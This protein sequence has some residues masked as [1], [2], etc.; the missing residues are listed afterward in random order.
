MS[1]GQDVAATAP[2]QSGLKSR[3]WP[4]FLR[5]PDPELLEKLYVPALNEAL[6]YDRC[7]AYF[8]SNVLAAAARG[9]GGLIQRLVS[10]GDTAPKPAVRLVVNE[11]LDPD[12]VRALIESGDTSALE[13]KLLNGLK[14]PRE[15]LQKQRLE[16][17]AW[18]TA[19][20]LLEVRVGV[21]RQGEGIVHAKYGIVTDSDKQSVV[22][23]GSGN[24]S[25]R[26]LLSNYERLE[27]ST[28]WGDPERYDEYRKEFDT[29]WKDE[30]ALVHTL[31]LPE[32][33]RLKLI[34]FAPKEPPVEHLTG[35]VA[36][37]KAAMMWRFLSEALYLPNGAAASDA[38][39]PVDLWPHQHRV[40]EETASA[41]PSGRL[42]C[43]EV[44]MGKT[45]EAI[46]VLRRLL[47]GRGVKRVLLLVPRGIVKQWQSELREKGGLVVPRLEGQNLLIWPDDTSENVGTLSEALK[48]DILLMS[49]E[50]ARLE[51]NRDVL[52]NA[53]SWDLV[54]LDEAHAA[55]RKKAEEGEFNQ[56]TLLLDLLRFLQLRRRT[57]SILL[58][59]ATP[60]QTHP[61][62]PWDLVGVLG[63][64]V[65]WLVEFSDVRKY[66]GALAAT[67]QGTCTLPDAQDAAQVIAVDSCFPPPP[68]GWPA[69]RNARAISQRIA[70]ATPGM[71][72]QIASWMR[73]G[74]ALHR[75]MH[76]NTRKTLREYY[77]RG[78]LAAPPPTR[79]V[80][81]VKF[82]YDDPAER[83]IYEAISA[84]IDKRYDEL[85][86]EK[87]GKGFVMTVYRR[88]ASSSPLALR[89][90]LER[91]REGLRRVTQSMATTAEILDEDVP[92]ALDI[93]DLPEGEDVQVSSAL[94]TD[95]KIAAAELVE[96]DRLLF[97]LRD[98]GNTDSKLTRFLTELRSAT[99]D[100][101]SVLIF[102]EYSDT[103]EYLRKTL[104]PHFGTALG[105]YSGD[106]GARWDGNSWVS[107]T[108]DDITRALQEGKLRALV[109]TDAASEGL[110]LQTAGALVNYDLPWNPSR[111][112][113]RI[114]RI[115]RIGQKFADI[116]IV[117]LFLKDSVDDKVY[118]A[119]RRRCG[120]FERFVGA[121]QPVL[122]IARKMLVSP[123]TAAPNMIIEASSGVENDVLAKE[124]YLDSSAATV[125]EATPAASRA[126]V[127]KAISALDGTFG[128]KFSSK[129]NGTFEFSAGSG[130]K[131][132]F[133]YLPRAL[134]ASRTAK[135]VMLSD[136]AIRDIADALSRPGERLPLVIGSAQQ[137]AF[138]VARL[139]WIAPNGAEELSTYEQLVEKLEEWDGSYPDS[140]QWQ[141]ALAQAQE[142]AAAAVSETV[143]QA[144]ELET[145]ARRAQVEAA[146]ARLL[147]ELGRYLV[148][149]T[150]SAVGLNRMLN[151]LMEA[152]RIS[153][154]RLR[155][156]L[157]RLGGEPVWDAEISREL[158]DFIRS[159]PP[160]RQKA[161]LIGSEIDAALR[162]PRW[163]AAS[164]FSQ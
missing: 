112:E 119:L 151:E 163:L 71:R 98:L 85:E 152:D 130:S 45:V 53:G 138:R 150:G 19:K 12:D 83:A 116:R 158:E 59:S 99:N 162:D 133:A 16:M 124:T 22:F 10:L 96:V 17:L 73:N 67:E 156:A 8:S 55:R 63:E 30:D 5:G 35:V 103:M 60:M 40:V 11:E 80:N 37:Q 100:G 134:E 127:L 24:E 38:T 21:M 9:F 155:K 104:I 29:I 52:L 49:R 74:A 140:Q 109:C 131:Q 117:N 15:A 113:Q 115:D 36:R 92:E 31:P 64:G 70:F 94:P 57:R 14:K 157:E 136:V 1:N 123:A 69:Q 68:G 27:L 18:L 91:R 143:K 58:L 75:R 153:A 43:D 61:W 34:K 81:D 4:R 66:F 47:S 77:E 7:C 65:P 139:K 147:R 111:V 86:S 128:P 79:T 110:N 135:P 148:C 129:Q 26:G 32:A 118:G 95:P 142:A 42:L 13:Q 87:G 20:G 51:P 2:A 72:P 120:L 126:D 122:S 3:E 25:A 145:I 160:N 48:Q 144:E 84:Y 114:G 23:N 46:M 89:R 39:A 141:A 93:D 146:K 41:W 149:F 101:R 33:V 6:R 76:R 108:K 56:G 44:G 102:T 137:G 62:E 106:G 28:S 97:Q 164:E 121:M 107:T 105:S 132:L 50:T 88:R 154:D 82:D 54:L 90:S 78:M 125:N 159:L 161:R